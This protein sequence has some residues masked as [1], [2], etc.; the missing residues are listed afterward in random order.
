[1]APEFSLEPLEAYAGY[2]FSFRPKIK[3]WPAPDVS[4]VTG[5]EGM[6]YDAQTGTVRWT[7]NANQTGRQQFT[8]K[9]ANSVGTVQQVFMIW[10]NSHLVLVG[11]H[12]TNRVQ[13][14]A[15]NDGS[16]GKRGAYVPNQVGFKMDGAGELY[17]GQLV[18]GKSP[19]QVSGGLYLYEFGIQS[20]VVP[21]ASGLSGFD[22]AYQTRFTDAKMPDPIGIEVVQRSHSK[23]TDPDRDYVIME[24]WIKNA[25]AQTLAGIYVGLAMD[26]DVGYYI[27]QGGKNRGGYDETHR[28]NYMV[29][30][31][32]TAAPKYFGVAALTGDVSGSAVWKNGSD[33]NSDGVLYDRMT[34]F[35]NEDESVPYDRRSML[36]VGPYTI[37]VGDSV[38]CIF[39]VL[40]GNSLDDL[41][42]NADTAAAKLASEGGWSV[43]LS[44]AFG[45]AP[46]LVRS[47][48]GHPDATD[49]Y[50]PALDVLSPPP[51]PGYP[52]FFEIDPFPYNLLKDMRRWVPPYDEAI[53]W[54]FGVDA[55][56][57][58]FALSWN[59]SDLP[60]QGNF[61]LVRGSE[62][63]NMRGST[64]YSFSGNTSRIVIQYRPLI[65]SPCHYK[66]DREGWYLISLP[67]VP[68][69]STVG[70]LFPSQNNHLAYS[71]DPATRSY[72]TN[73][74][75]EPGRA[76][77]MYFM[78]PMTCTVTG[79]RLR[80]YTSRYEAQGWFLAGSPLG[81][82]DFSNPES[83]PE[84][85]VLSPVFG[86]DP[87]ALAYFSTA[88]ME[89]NQ[90]YWIAVIGPCVLTV[91][92][93]YA[94][95]GKGMKSED[96]DTFCRK[97]G[98]TPPGPPDADVA[99]WKPQE[100]ILFQNYPNPFNA[101][102]RIMYA[103]PEEAEVDLTVYDTQ[104]RV[105]QMWKEGRQAYGGHTVIWNGSGRPSGM[106]VIELKAGSFRQIKKCVLLK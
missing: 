102:T 68:Q 106:Y 19:S 82:A 103:L 20:A 14:T 66:I 1:F 36:S 79:A 57:A 58:S 30:Y 2:P 98:R 24:Y 59:P 81:G 90:G 61:T 92:G 71:W 17:E 23:S 42:A 50:D 65:E 101:E 4:L 10:V 104:G 72:I 55:Q 49:G 69:D 67:V 54:T 12:N 33:D 88:A 53:D 100:Y 74:K 91:N 41:K 3:G 80:R 83:D 28:L 56:N 38:R 89:E 15:L 52:A 48:G 32:E 13:F 40:G 105:V 25:T 86:W 46:A 63:T 78:G 93:R 26:W 27:G 5:P 18:I 35:S 95:M 85:Q 11:Q 60:P 64:Q 9:A 44:A 96:W 16:V 7:P 94:Q 51:P 39:A 22:Q 97:F 31:L 77:W 84:G 37:P 29:G 73:E 87:N 34:H 8:L 76:Y 21:I 70:K 47:F 45:N 75:M 6:T 62:R 99:R 43:S